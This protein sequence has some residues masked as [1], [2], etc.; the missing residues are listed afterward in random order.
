VLLVLFYKPV[1]KEIQ[2]WKL[3]VKKDLG[4]ILLKLQKGEKIG[5]PDISPM[6]TVSAGVFE[7]R[8]KDPSGIFRVFFIIKSEIGILI[9]HS[10]VKKTQKTPLH[11]INIGRNRLKNFLRDF[12]N[13][14]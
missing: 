7:I 12:E 8:I 6:K 13:E 11:E 14:K 1:R 4:S 9:F 10:F 5:F 2:R 3:E